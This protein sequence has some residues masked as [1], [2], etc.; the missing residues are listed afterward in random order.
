MGMSLRQCA[1]SYSDLRTCKEVAAHP[2]GCKS[3]F[4]VVVN[5]APGD[6][7]TSHSRTI[8]SAEPGRF[9]YLFGRRGS[10]SLELL[11]QSSLVPEAQHQVTAPLL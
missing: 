5:D 8:V 2:A 6:H 4:R 9:R 7:N 10:Q 1:Q 3:P 11:E